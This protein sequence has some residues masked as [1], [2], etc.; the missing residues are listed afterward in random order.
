MPLDHATFHNMQPSLEEVRRSLVVFCGEWRRREA[1][2]FVPPAAYKCASDETVLLR[3]CC[4]EYTPQTTKS[5][6]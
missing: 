2:H 5:S 3:R 4:Y 6:M 1:T